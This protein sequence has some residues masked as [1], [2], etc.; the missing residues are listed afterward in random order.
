MKQKILDAF[1]E[2]LIESVRD[3]SIEISEMIITGKMGDRRLS[4]FID[5]IL[6]SEPKYQELFEVIINRVVDTTLGHLLWMI[7]QEE[8]IDIIY[9]E[10]GKSYSIK[11]MSDG[12]KGEL[13]TEDGWIARYSN[14]MH[15]EEE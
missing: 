6:A 2:M 1:G 3:E 14:K 15:F 10:S 11:D 4:K 5:D 7:E 9:N 8:N 12:L 13:Y